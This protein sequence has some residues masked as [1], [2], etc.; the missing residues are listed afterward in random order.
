[1]A[2]KLNPGIY[3]ITD[4]ANDRLYVGSSN[5]MKRRWNEHKNALRN[6]VHANS[7]LQNAFDKYGEDN[8]VFEALESCPVDALAEREAFWIGHYGTLDRS[9]GYNLSDVERRTVCDETKQKLSKARMGKKLSEETKRK[10]SEINTGRRFNL[11]DEQKQKIS[12]G[13]KGKKKSEAHRASLSAAHKGRSYS[14]AQKKA[15]VGKHNNK[16]TYELACEIRAKYK[17][18]G[19]RQ[20]D[21]ANE[22]GVSGRTIF[23]IIHN[24]YHAERG[25]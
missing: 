18:G 22:Y 7:Y 13:N 17:A 9:K 14:E 3:L 19:V 4:K 5:S 1:M 16:L 24:K 2:Y 23:D 6:G 15:H 8:F 12:A 25:E 20:I 10:L 21:L 11:T